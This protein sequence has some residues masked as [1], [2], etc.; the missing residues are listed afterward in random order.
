M[1]F[2]ADA[3]KPVLYAS[4]RLGTTSNT[5][6]ITFV[7]NGGY[8]LLALKQVKATSYGV[9]KFL[10]A[11]ANFQDIHHQT[12][13]FSVQQERDGRSKI[14]NLL[15][16]NAI[17]SLSVLPVPEEGYQWAYFT[18]PEYGQK[19]GY[20]KD[21]ILNQKDRQ[22]YEVIL[23]QDSH[24]SYLMVDQDYWYGGSLYFASEKYLRAKGIK[25]M[26]FRFSHL[27]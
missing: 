5:G 6:C 18:T 25:P 19:N 13:A 10:P 24:K 16:S 2:A 17:S 14:Q 4:P 21:F 12:G 11:E 27:P 23:Y 3:E 7:D 22:T 20:L 1:S 9:P 15:A 8:R 26:E